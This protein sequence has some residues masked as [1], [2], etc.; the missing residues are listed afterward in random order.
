MRF[1][2]LFLLIFISSCSELMTKMNSNSNFN[3]PLEA[4]LDYSQANIFFSHN[5]SGETH[6]CGCRQFPLGGLPQVYGF[7]KKSQEK[8]A[9]I[10]VDSGDTFFPSNKIPDTVKS[11][12]SFAAKNLARGLDQ[13]SLRYLTPGDQDFAMGIEFL[14]EIA[15][16][17]RFEFLISNFNESESGKLK[18]TKFGQQK[19]A[20][21]EYFFIGLIDPDTFLSEE[22]KYFKP[23]LESL[24]D[25]LEEIKKLGYRSN[26]PRHRLIVLSH[27]GMEKDRELALRFPQIDWI[28][29][30]H[31]Q[32]FLR[33]SE[34]V[35]S[36]KIV[37]VLSKN[38][39]LGHIKSYLEKNKKFD[40]YEIVE[41]RDELSK[42]V[43]NNPLDDFIAQH[44]SQMN[45]WQ[46]K[47]QSSLT[48]Q[49][50][51]IHHN[52]E[53]TNVVKKFPH[54]KTCINCH[55]VQ[56]DFWQTTSHSIAYTT[57]INA[58]EQNNLSC[59]KCHSVGLDDPRGFSTAK[60]IVG[61]KE[62]PI[63]DYWM[64]AASLGKHVKSVRQL[65]PNEIKKISR[66][67]MK[68]DEKNKVKH[69]FANVQCLNCHTYYE[70]H[71]FNMQKDG[72]A[73]SDLDQKNLKQYQSKC[74]TCHTPDQSPEWYK[75]KNDLNEQEFQRKLKKVSCPKL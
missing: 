53:L 2:Y 12:L 34:D 35:G 68:L 45:E 70:E 72:D 13:L 49:N 6:P 1:L 73:Y 21:A 24:K 5:I 67:W 44:K 48:S 66:E 17:S 4:H 16:S 29:G 26:N 7:M 27:S 51:L 61:F 9:Y 41:I 71:P 74:V 22:K 64:N 18:H 14:D 33:Y 43:Q 75:K 59:I 38:H 54:P 31:T 32:N 36:V 55:K 60:S 69:N 37:Q 57:L 11:S 30:S 47:E 3:S 23:I 58:K 42:L 52:P 28:I 19:I 46:L 8:N 20:D 39:Y 15:K 50:N 63:T 10:Y 40:Q 62:K 65:P 25:N 56:G